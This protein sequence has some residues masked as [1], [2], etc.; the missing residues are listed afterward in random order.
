MGTKV[1]LEVV[2]I[3]ESDVID[4]LKLCSV[5]QKLGIKGASRKVTVYV[6]G[7]GSGRLQF[8]YPDGE[9]LPIPE[10]DVDD[11]PLMYIGE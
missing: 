2:G 5:I 3:S 11:L 4:F 6:D 8:Y 1:V 7:D 10:V 9:L